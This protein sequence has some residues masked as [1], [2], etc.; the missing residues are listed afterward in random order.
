MILAKEQ[1]QPN[2]DLVLQDVHILTAAPLPSL[3]SLPSGVRGGGRE[4]GEG[5]LGDV[6]E[7]RKITHMLNKVTDNAVIK[8][9]HLFPWYALARGNMAN[10]REQE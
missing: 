8:V 1:N 7:I 9:V 10:Y 2:L 6:P 4:T 5:Y 3:T